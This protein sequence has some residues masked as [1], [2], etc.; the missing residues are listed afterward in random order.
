MKKQN[1]VSLVCV[2]LVCVTVFGCGGATRPDGL[3]K[4][5]PCTLTI[6]YEDGSPVA[7]AMVALA[8]E[9]IEMGKFSMSGKT[10]ASGQ[11]VIRTH[12]DFSGAPE[13]KY[14]VTV[15]KV[16]WV[17]SGKTDETGSPIMKA[18]PHVASEFSSGVNS[19]LSLTIGVSSVKETLKVK[20]P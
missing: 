9:N 11:V 6:Q 1:V 13:G 19:P 16:D 5:V 8:P 18:N 15:S 7:D 3:P 17:D 12:G 10:N 20:K 4:L 14:R 2:A